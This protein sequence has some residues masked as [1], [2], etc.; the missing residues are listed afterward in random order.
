M[1]VIEPIIRN[2]FVKSVGGSGMSLDTEIQGPFWMRDIATPTLQSNK[3]NL[4]YFTAK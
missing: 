3:N 4:T 2:K 1:H